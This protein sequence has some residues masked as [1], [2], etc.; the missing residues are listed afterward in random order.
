MIHFF[1]YYSYDEGFQLMYVGN[2]A[3]CSEKKYHLPL[4]QR[5]KEEAIKKH[6]ETLLKEV[7]RQEQLPRIL[8]PTQGQNCGWPTK[9]NKLISHGGYSLIFTHLEDERFILARRKIAGEKDIYGRPT[10]FLFA[11]LCDEQADLPRLNALATFMAQYPRKSEKILSKAL[12]HDP[13]E[14]GLCFEQSK[15]QQWLKDAITECS[16][17][18]LKLT[19]GKEIQIIS[20]KDKISLL[21]TPDGIK[22]MDTLDELSLGKKAYYMFSESQILLSNKI[23][24]KE[25]HI[26]K[27]LVV[28]QE[29]KKK[30]YLKVI[31]IAI[32][33]LALGSLAC[34]LLRS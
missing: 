13:F 32:A 1:S 8:I 10:T 16:N 26:E 15:I 7:A 18:N 22:S 2:E 33:V 19:N 5:D 12:H 31:G 28:E 6:D 21:I 3:D 24:T 27:G 25:A 14:N 17:S 4:L 20:S 11:F 23:E 9:A 34:Y 30:S 29:S